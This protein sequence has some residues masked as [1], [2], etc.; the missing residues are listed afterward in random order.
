LSPFPNDLQSKLTDV[1]EANISKADLDERNNYDQ[2]NAN[3]NI[4][5]QVYVEDC[6]Y[7]SV[8]DDN[9]SYNE[10][11]NEKSFSSAPING[12]IAKQKSL[13][14]ELDIDVNK[15]T[16]KN[17]FDNVLET[18]IDT[19]RN[20]DFYIDTLKKNDDNR[21]GENHDIKK[22]NLLRSASKSSLIDDKSNKSLLSTNE[23]LEKYRSSSKLS[24]VSSD[25]MNTSLS[26]EMFSSILKDRDSKSQSHSYAS[27]SSE[28][29]T[30][31]TFRICCASSCILNSDSIPIN[32]LSINS[33]EENGKPLNDNEGEMHDIK[34]FELNSE[35]RNNVLNE[36]KKR[37]LRE[38]GNV[39]KISVPYE[40][41]RYGICF[42]PFL[43]L[44]LINI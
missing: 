37:N 27:E 34:L 28:E 1:S 7:D 38:F 8:Y 26:S 19:S 43:I 29:L 14:A 5:E 39:D 2:Q 33:K 16:K 41:V 20:M 18:L 11:A 42:M 40:N 23:D 32:W 24:D 31:V 25:S 17:N 21:T 22:E 9:D 6:I 13:I 15:L 35:W 4:D 10:K 3:E 12:K 44:F 36:L 30:D